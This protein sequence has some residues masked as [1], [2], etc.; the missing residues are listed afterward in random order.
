[1]AVSNEMRVTLASISEIDEFIGNPMRQCAEPPRFAA[2]QQRYKPCAYQSIEYIFHDFRGGAVVEFSPRRLQA[3][4][5][6]F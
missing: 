2:V 4:G 5:L 3:R 6:H 1:M